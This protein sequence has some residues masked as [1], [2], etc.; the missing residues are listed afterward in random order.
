MNLFASLYLDQDVAVLV[1]TFD[2]IADNL[3]YI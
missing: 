2:E 1:E 3:F